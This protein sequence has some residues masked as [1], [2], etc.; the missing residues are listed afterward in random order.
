MAI[1]TFSL[2]RTDEFIAAQSNATTLDRFVPPHTNLK[3]PG[4]TEML[5]ELTDS[6]LQILL[7]TAQGYKV[8][9]ISRAFQTNRGISLKGIYKKYKVENATQ[10]VSLAIQHNVLTLNMLQDSFEFDRV[11][12][13]TDLQV[14]LLRGLT[15]IDRLNTEEAI[16]ENLDM[17]IQS[18]HKEFQKM[19][20]TFSWETRPKA[21]AF[22]V[23]A[24][25]QNLIADEEIE[26]SSSQEN[27]PTVPP[28]PGFPQRPALR[29]RA[30]GKNHAF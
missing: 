28:F 4:R 29:K 22:Y 20:D 17:T 6:E 19:C 27:I 26:F 5:P 21:A 9:D 12:E 7:Y 24:V 13:L 10:A 11:G 8:K 18:V 16:G 23:L 25:K 3:E 14:A 1:E 2:G 30:V 15:V